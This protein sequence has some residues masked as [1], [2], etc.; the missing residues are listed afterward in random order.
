MARQ[1]GSIGAGLAQSFAARLRARRALFEA[2]PLYF[3]ALALAGPR[4]WRDDWWRRHRDRLR[5]SWQAIDRPLHGPG[6][7]DRQILS[8]AARRLKLAAGEDSK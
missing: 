3:A 7:L 8:R 1:F 4:A 6:W 5:W 2:Q